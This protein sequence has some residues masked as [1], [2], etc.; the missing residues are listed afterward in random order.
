[1]KIALLG[2]IALFGKFSLENN[3]NLDTYFKVVSEKLETYDLVIGNLETPFVEKGTSSFGYKSAYIKS[4]PEDIKL[5]KLLNID[6]VNLANNHIYDFGRKS[7]EQTKTLLD[8]NNIKYFGVENDQ[9]IIERDGNKIALNG[10]CCYSTNPLGINSSKS[11]GINEL[12]IPAVESTLIENNENELFSIFST[13][14]GQEHVNF[15]NY[16]HIQM[17]RGLAHKAPLVYYG[18]HPHVAQGI[19]KVEN[20]LLAYSLG[21]FCFDDVYTSKSKD[22]LIK[23]TENNK[24]S[25]ILE[26]EIKDNVLIDYSIVPIYLGEEE[27]V[28]GN[29]D[30]KEKIKSYSEALMMDEIEYKQM[31]SDL[32]FT[33]ISSRK[34]QRDLNWY[35][36]RLNFRSF[37]LILF[38]KINASKYKKS[39]TNHLK[40]K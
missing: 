4:N 25:F 28:I 37:R 22:P 40:K 32:L 20:S 26:I 31:R 27:M 5:L 18:H 30:I 35:L 7:Y 1:M 15:P 19:E 14:C 38:A 23:Q 2:D 33:Y 21:N 39:I 24:E 6:I 13:H 9:L 36:K 34:K 8:E 29:S 16:D 17:A 11:N 3:D 12:N 10:Y